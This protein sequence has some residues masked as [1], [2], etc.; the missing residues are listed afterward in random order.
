MSQQVF[1]DRVGKSK[2]WVDKVERGLRTLDRLS[3]IETVAGVLGVAPEVLTGQTARRA[4]AT[5]VAGAVERMRAA[6]A[7]YDLP[8]T[9]A[10]RRPAPT[11]Q[12]LDLRVGY[13]W[14]AYRHAHHPQVLRTLPDLLA[15]TRHA[16]QTEPATGPRPAA[17]LL[18]RVYRLT[19]QLLVKLGEP[20]LA[21]L[22]ADRAMAT[23]AGDPQRTA[24]AAIPLAQ[25]LRALKRGRLAMAATITAVQQL[26]PPPRR[27]FPP[28]D[29]ALAGT[30]LIEAA[31]AAATCGDATAVRDL[32]NHAAHLAATHGDRPEPDNGDLGFGPTVVNLARALTAANLGDHQQAITTH[33]HATN[34]ATWP[35]LPAEH[36]AA[37]LIDITRTHLDL[38]DPHAAG[39]ALLTADHIAPDETRTR[40]ATHTALTA[41]LRAGP[42]P[43]DLTRLATTIGLTRP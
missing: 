33:H 38:G 17:G 26:A 20:D 7:C 4:P 35:Q 14:T 32:T 36:R 6:L 2:S 28:D 19:A 23:A 16:H 24:A 31:L 37:H 25:A 8:E 22:A 5:D 10:D 27:E 42:A 39:R 18:V 9:G 15:D 1:A 29:L 11:A 30:L 40:P 41:I 13:A 3:V 43:A 12:E 34:S 21:W